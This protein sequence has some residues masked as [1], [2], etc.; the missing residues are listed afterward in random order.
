MLERLVFILGFS[1]LL[2]KVLDLLVLLFPDLWVWHTAHLLLKLFLLSLELLVLGL[3]LR[4]DRSLS[5]GYFRESLALLK[6]LFD[7]VRT[8]K[9]IVVHFGLLGSVH[10]DLLEALFVEV[11]GFKR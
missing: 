7:V 10:A 9:V 1:E 6:Q 4:D 11:Q 2:L 5:L 8:I 3:S